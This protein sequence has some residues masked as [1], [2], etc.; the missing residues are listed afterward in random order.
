MNKVPIILVLCVNYYNDQQTFRFVKDIL[1]QKNGFQLHVVI[2]DNSDKLNKENPLMELTK[3]KRVFLYQMGKNLGYFGA[4]AFGLNK[5]LERFLLPEWIIVCNTDIKL[6]FN[7]FFSHLVKHFEN[8]PPAIVA[9]SIISNFTGT[10]QNPYMRRRPCAARMHFY[11]LVFR[12]RATFKIYE[13]ISLIKK[14][15]IR[16]AKFLI[17]NYTGDK[18]TI[19]IYAPHGSFMIFHKN[20]FNRGGSLKYKVFLFGEEIFIAE[21]AL[22][23]G[24]KIIYYPELRVI[25][26]EHFTTAGFKYKAKYISEASTYCADNLFPLK[27]KIHR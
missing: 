26:Y 21:T 27:K 12:Y 18:K 17:K 7:D 9:P 24:L 4:V 2:I 16:S 5:Y 19:P 25:H 14:N 22:K 13:Y 10:D 20:Y 23:L 15:I 1:T 11:K 8:E 3:D 6:G